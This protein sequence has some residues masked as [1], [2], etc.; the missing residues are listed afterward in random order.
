MQHLLD[1]IPLSRTADPEEIVHPVRLLTSGFS[2]MTA[3]R[4]SVRRA[5]EFLSKSHRKK[6][7]MPFANQKEEDE[8]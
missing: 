2:R 4:S 3:G 1:S 5:I 7:K 6:M 8:S